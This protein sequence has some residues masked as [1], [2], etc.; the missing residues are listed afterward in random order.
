MIGVDKS[1]YRLVNRSER[2][3]SSEE[4]LVNYLVFLGR[5]E[6]IVELPRTV[7][8]CGDLRINIRLLPDHGDTFLVPRVPHVRESEFEIRPAARYWFHM[9]RPAQFNRCV[10]RVR[11]SHVHGDRDV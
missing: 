7:M 11:G 1:L 4:D 2:K 9:Y 5:D 6:N 10:S 8:E 3:V